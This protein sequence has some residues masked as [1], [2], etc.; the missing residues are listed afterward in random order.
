MIGIPRLAV[1]LAILIAAVLLLLTVRIYTNTRKIISGQ[2]WTVWLEE[3]ILKVYRDG[4]HEVP[5]SNIQL[6]RTTRRLLMLG[7]LNAK[8]HL[9]WIIVP[10]RVFAKAQ[11]RE[12][13]LDRIRHPQEI[14][15]GDIEEETEGMRFIYM[16]DESRWVHFR[17]DA[18]GI[19]ASGTFGRRK[20]VCT[21][22][23]RVFLLLMLM[24]FFLYQAEGYLNWLAVGYGLGIAVLLT[25]RR[26]LRDPEKS[27]R[28][29]IR[30]PAVR[31][32]EC[33]V[34]QITLSESG[35][36]VK[37][38]GGMKN[39][40][41]WEK[42]EWLV[43]TGDAFY[44]F[45]KDKRHYELI[46]KESFADQEQISAMHMLCAR[47]NIKSIQGRKMHYLPDWGLV[48]LVVLFV[49]LSVAIL[50]ASILKAV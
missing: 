39:N 2:Q 33:G 18:E 22:L 15:G 8:Q 44:F 29:Q 48:L 4:C 9:V 17:R 31:D 46:A 20:R 24:L 7:Y 43:E 37:M 26:F 28:K 1:W 42:F 40:Y 23:L 5:C 19:I 50:T 11:E 27:F 13:F 3:G 49:V 25:A 45:H 21:A 12:S 10:L 36:C 30:M 35:V 32:K 34:W 16:L 47:K 41:A 6:I 14:E 38:P